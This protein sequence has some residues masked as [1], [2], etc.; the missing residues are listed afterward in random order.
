[1]EDSN[2]TGEGLQ[3]EDEVMCFVAVALGMAVSVLLTAWLLASLRGMQVSAMGFSPF[4]VLGLVGHVVRQRALQ[5]WRRHSSK[6]LLVR[7]IR[8]FFIGLVWPLW[9]KV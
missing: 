7:F 1:M 9:I 3:L 5:D 8:A 2:E 6:S 4:W